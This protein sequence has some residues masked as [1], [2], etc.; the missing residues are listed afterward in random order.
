LARPDFWAGFFFT[1]QSTDLG[2]PWWAAWAKTLATREFA[3]WSTQW[4]LIN[5]FM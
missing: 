5:T 2:F 4:R 1:R 3:V